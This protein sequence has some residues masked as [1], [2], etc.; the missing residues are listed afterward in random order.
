MANISMEVIPGMFFFIFSSTKVLFAEKKLIW[1]FYTTAKVLPITK[2]VNL[3]NKKKFA[4]AVLNKNSK[5]FVI[6]IAVLETLLSKLLIYQDKKAQ[7]T[8]FF[9]KKVTI[10]DEYS[11]FAD[12]FSNKKALVLLEQANLNKHAIKL[13]SNK[14]PPY[15]SIYS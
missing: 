12:V 9:I 5:I 4:K 15:K 6:Y 10:P 8:S 3:I 13:E 2:W 14:Q 1:E 11:I 7:I